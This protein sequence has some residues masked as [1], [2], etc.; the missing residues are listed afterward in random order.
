MTTRKQHVHTAVANTA[1]EAANQ[2][3][4]TVMT[5]NMIYTEWRRQNPDADANELRKR[6]VKCNWGK[7]VPF[8]RATMARLL[9]TSTDPVL[10]E[11]VYE[12][13]CL[14][15][16]LMRGRGRKVPANLI[17]NFRP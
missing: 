7:C 17:T 4:D 14:D 10:K 12:A 2:L 3:Y 11:A 16:S 6:F 5:D 9:V 13:L 8:A 15:D 1:M